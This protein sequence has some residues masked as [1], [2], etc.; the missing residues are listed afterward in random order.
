MF[1]KK[2]CSLSRYIVTVQPSASCYR[3]SS[4]AKPLRGVKATYRGL[5]ILCHYAISRTLQPVQSPE[6]LRIVTKLI[7]MILLYTI[8][9]VLLRG[10]MEYLKK[11]NIKKPF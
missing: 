2:I 9:A 8:F 3:A 1:V 6:L 11:P 10:C 4:H 5:M 7:Y